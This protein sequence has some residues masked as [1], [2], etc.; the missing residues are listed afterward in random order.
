MPY[1]RQVDNGETRLLTGQTITYYTNERRLVAE[2]D[3]K[4]VIIPAPPKKAAGPPKAA[5]GKK[6]KKSTWH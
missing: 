5:A 3:V 2:K 1:A 4:T 6:K